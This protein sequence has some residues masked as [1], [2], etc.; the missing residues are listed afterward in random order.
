MQTVH[1]TRAE[2]TGYAETSTFADVIAFCDALVKQYAF[3][4]RET[5]CRSAEGRDVPLLIVSKPGF[6]SGIPGH[7]SHFHLSPT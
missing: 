4:K 7:N 6:N 1:Q 5:L 2:A 3:V